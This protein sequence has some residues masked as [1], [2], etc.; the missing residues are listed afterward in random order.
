MRSH[1]LT[2]IAAVAVVLGGVA[3]GM[4]ATAPSASALPPGCLGSAMRFSDYGVLPS[5]L[6]VYA[7]GY[8]YWNGCSYELPFNLSIS[9]YVTGVGWEK[10]ATGS[11][12]VTYSCTGGPA[13]YTTDVTPAGDDFSCG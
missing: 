11:G 12:A 13:L 7:Q 6:E 1:L 5:P 10:V 9:K 3:G 4:A 2:R 8:W